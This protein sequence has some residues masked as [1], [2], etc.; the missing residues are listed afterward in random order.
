[1]SIREAD[2][3]TV[4]VVSNFVPSTIASQYFSA[5]SAL[6]ASTVSVS[7]QGSTGLVGGNF[8][9]SGALLSGPTNPAVNPAGPGI[10]VPLAQ[11]KLDR[12]KSI[13]K[14][15]FRKTGHLVRIFTAT[16]NNGVA[17]FTYDGQACSTKYCLAMR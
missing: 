2:W 3:V 13:F 12:Y 11:V 6:S 16:V 8:S 17:Q 10:L 1:M 15:Y 4:P 7:Q 14:G 9:I 5:V